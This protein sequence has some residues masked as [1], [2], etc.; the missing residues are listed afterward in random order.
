MKKFAA[1]SSVIAVFVRF[2]VSC[3]DDVV[4]SGPIRVSMSVVR[5][6]TPGRDEALVAEL[7]TLLLD[8]LL[9]IIL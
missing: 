7:L 9:D 5:D 1:C 8:E 4:K 3:V 6:G 2:L